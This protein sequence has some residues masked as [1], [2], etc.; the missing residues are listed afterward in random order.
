MKVFL[1]VGSPYTAQQK[2]WIDAFRRFLADNKH[3]VLTVGNEKADQPILGAR[4][5]I[6]E[7]DC[8]VVLAYTRFE[9]V[10]V[11]E[12]PGAEDSNESNV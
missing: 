1:S 8:L 11:I 6:R 4:E 3:Q 7:A 9:F 2:A 12:K 5:L 10:D